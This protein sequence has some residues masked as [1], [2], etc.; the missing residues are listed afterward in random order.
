LTVSRLAD[1]LLKKNHYQDAYQALIT[2]KSF[3]H[4]D[5]PVASQACAQTFVASLSK[6][7]NLLSAYKQ[8]AN[9]ASYYRLSQELNHLAT[10]YSKLKTS[11]KDGAGRKTNSVPAAMMIDETPLQ[12]EHPTLPP[13]PPAPELPALARPFSLIPT[14]VP[15]PGQHVAWSPPQD[16]APVVSHASSASLFGTLQMPPT[17]EWKGKQ[18]EVKSTSGSTMIEL[19]RWKSCPWCRAPVDCSWPICPAAGC[20]RPIVQDNLQPL[21]QRSSSNAAPLS[22]DTGKSWFSNLPSLKLPSLPFLGEEPQVPVEG[23]TLSV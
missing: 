22:L 6:S 23:A 7:R 13:A 17:S 11:L 1:G 10:H 8:E 2:D 16:A 12:L 18:V 20:G 14:E 5:V 4:R 9:W 21:S 15:A 3:D 19:S